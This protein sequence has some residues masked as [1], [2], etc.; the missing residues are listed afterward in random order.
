MIPTIFML[1]TTILTA[2]TRN[3]KAKTSLQPSVKTLT[4][5]LYSTP[6]QGSDTIKIIL[7]MPKCWRLLAKLGIYP[8]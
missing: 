3:K 8:F 4:G 5:K 7:P 6:F 1:T 2:L